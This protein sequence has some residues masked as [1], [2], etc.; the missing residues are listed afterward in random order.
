MMDLSKSHLLSD[1]KSSPNIRD[2]RK[3]PFR[4]ARQKVNF[5]KILGIKM[6]ETIK[7]G[8]IALPSIDKNSATA[9]SKDKFAF[10]LGLRSS[11]SEETDASPRNIYSK[12]TRGEPSRP[13]KRLCSLK[14]NCFEDGLLMIDLTSPLGQR[15]NK[16]TCINNSLSNY[17]IY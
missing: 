10:A 9:F 17:L 3:L 11:E 2:I 14:L 12:Q 5:K 7:T 16:D 6:K 15:I 1:L 13:K 8:V 4:A